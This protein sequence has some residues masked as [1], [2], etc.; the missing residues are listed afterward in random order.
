MTN[1]KSFS[2]IVYHMLLYQCDSKNDKENKGG[3][4]RREINFQPSIVKLTIL[5]F[6]EHV[7]LGKGFFFPS[8]AFT[9]G[10]TYG[11]FRRLQEVSIEN[12]LLKNN[13]IWSTKGCWS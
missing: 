5:Y 8:D 6:L 2:Q 4:V 12:N 7:L 13:I 11:W 10:S 9:L 1:M 3:K